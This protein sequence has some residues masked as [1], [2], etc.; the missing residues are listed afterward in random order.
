M[1]RRTRNIIL[2]ILGLGIIG[3]VIF[4]VIPGGSINADF[5]APGNPPVTYTIQWDS[6]QTEQL[7]RTA[8][9]DCHSNETRYPWYSNIAPMDWLVNSD[10]NQ[11]RRKM[12]FSTGSKLF[13]D[14]MEKQIESGEMPKALYLPLHPEANLTDA[15]KK[16]LIDGLI[17]TFGEGDCSC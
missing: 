2:G 14:E 10:I 8:C 7:A 5:A 13:S 4:Q 9:F 16:Q 17:A 1:S 11:A 12:N 15:Q 6:P 3:F